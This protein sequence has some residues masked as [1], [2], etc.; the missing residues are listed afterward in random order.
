MLV[1]G[2]QWLGLHQVN[3]LIRSYRFVG[4]GS[5]SALE[6]E[7]VGGEF[8]SRDNE[9]LRPQAYSFRGQSAFSAYEMLSSSHQTG[10]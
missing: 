6:V 10:K 7:T 3:F 5:S 8:W 1:P 9:R 2:A 4:V